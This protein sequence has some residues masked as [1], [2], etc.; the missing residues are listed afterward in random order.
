MTTISSRIHRHDLATRDAS[1]GAR[2]VTTH[3]SIVLRSLIAVALASPG[4]A[5][6]APSGGFFENFDGVTAPALPTGWTASVDTGIASDIPWQTKAAGF[7]SSSPNVVWVGDINDYADIT[8]TSPPLTLAAGTSRTI[9]FQQ[10]YVLWSPDASPLANGAY[11][12]AVLEISING[13][14]FTDFVAAGGVFTVGGYNATL[15]PN[16]DNPLAQTPPLNRSV[17]SG[18]SGALVTTTGTLP[19]AV[20]GGATIQLRWRLGTEGGGRSFNT[21]SGW[22]IDDVS[23][24]ACTEGNVDVI[25]AN[26]FDP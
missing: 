26:G 22:W 15:D 1:Q 21:F 13:G 7:S 12:G 19:D 4:L 6:A 3:S 10:A 23:C 16:F 8:L 11:N 2:L 24:P 25:F 14:A 9:T 20:P 18:N 5:L 17:W